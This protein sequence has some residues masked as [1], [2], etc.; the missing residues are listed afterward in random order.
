MMDAHRPYFSNPTQPTPQNTPTHIQALASVPAFLGLLGVGAD[1]SVPATEQ[2][3]DDAYDRAH[4]LLGAL[5]TF[6]GITRRLK[7][8]VQDD[9]SS[10]DPQLAAVGRVV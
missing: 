3:W 5:N 7:V 1:G 10:K 9:I 4:A 8:P 6:L 2:Q